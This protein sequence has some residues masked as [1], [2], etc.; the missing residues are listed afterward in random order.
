MNTSRELI[1]R[2]VTRALLIVLLLAAFALLS[3][4]YMEPDRIVGDGA[5]LTVGS[6]SVPFQNIVPS[7]TATPTPTPAPTDPQG[8]QTGGQ[9]GGW[10][11]TPPTGGL[12]TQPTSQVI[13]ITP[14]P[15]LTTPTP[16]PTTTTGTL[17]SGSSGDA[18]KNLQTRLKELQYYKGAIDG[19]YGSGTT[20][21][22]KAFQAAN[23]LTADGVAGSA[24]LKALESYYAIPASAVSTSRTTT[25][26]T[27]K[28]V[29]VT[30]RPTATPNLTKARYLQ[31]GSTGSDVRVVQKRLID[32]GY[33]L[34]NA[35]G[36]YGASTEAAVK[37]FQKRHSLWDDGIAGP[38]TQKT[39][40]SSSAKKAT[41]AASSVGESLKKGMEGSAVKL[42]QQKLKKLGFL[43]GSADGDFGDATETAVKDFQRA[44]GLKADGVAG[45]STL[46]KLYSS[47]AI[48]KSQSGSSSGGSSSGGSSGSGSSTG[49][50]TLREGDEGEAVRQ[51]Q[52]KLA[53]LGYYAGA[54][55]GKYGAG[56]V[57]AVQSYQVLNNLTADGVAGPATQRMIFGDTTSSADTGVAASSK[58]E[59]GDVGASVYDLQYTLYELGYYQGELNSTYDEPTR[60]AVREFQMN[61][62]LRVDGVAGAS[63]LTAIY[64]SYAKPAAAVTVS[65]TTLRKGAVGD[66]VVQLQDA[67]VKLGYLYDPISGAY[68]DDTVNAIKTFQTY[69]GLNVDGIAGA[70]TQQT[71]Y[72]NGAV[73]NPLAY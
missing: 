58:L 20:S 46:N 63:T 9:Q 5:G 37:A 16:T 47:S 18:V 24:T 40:Y 26:T 64:S 53:D 60:L 30:T 1:R 51:L 44:N 6:D 12:P 3:G 32:L 29:T 34:G 17:K 27:K 69:N 22:V 33:L 65:Y 2:R 14:T 71:L 11:D 56:T 23:G 49:Y 31:L 72:G 41:T 59:D 28:P 39:L 8:G 25:T 55:D 36:T 7:P 62:G 68:D 70:T 19:D 45:T 48:S 21:A 52:R 54:I 67:L 50:T 38:D 57:L 66:E 15:P 73:R 42:L 4:C 43:T 13:T 10:I 35:D 61:N